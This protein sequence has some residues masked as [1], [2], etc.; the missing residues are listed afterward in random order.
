MNQLARD[1]QTYKRE[2][3]RAGKEK[4]KGGCP[5]K[6]KDDADEDDQDGYPNIEGIMIISGGPQAYE[7]RRSKKV[8]RHLI[9]ATAPTLPIYLRWL[10][11]P[12]TFNKDDHPDHVV[13]AGR[14]PLVVSVVIGGV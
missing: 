8:T 10:E 4:S 11:R 6:G 12:I 3:I 1:Y 5:K 13:K 2:V 9:F 14:F 7:D